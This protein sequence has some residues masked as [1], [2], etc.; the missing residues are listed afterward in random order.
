LDEKL[1]QIYPDRLL[2]FKDVRQRLKI[3]DSKLREMLE[4]GELPSIRGLGCLKVSEYTLNTYIK[5]KELNS[6]YK[7]G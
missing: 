6:A 4:S 1:K 5:K 3:Q 2:T 7:E